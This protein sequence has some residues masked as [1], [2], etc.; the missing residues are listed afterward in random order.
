VSGS[1]SGETSEKV[2]DQPSFR[3]YVGNY[4]FTMRIKRFVA[5]ATALLTLALLYIYAAGRSERIAKFI[6]YKNDLKDA[7]LELHLGGSFANHYNH[8][9]VH[10]F[11]NYY[12]IDG[13]NYQCEFVGENEDFKNWGRLA[14][15]TNQVYLWIDKK[16]RVTPLLNHNT[17]L[18]PEL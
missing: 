4:L 8:T 1:S 11:T 2:C 14:I 13:T 12:V 15:T 9:V 10:V 6:N 17:T 18:P 3:L 16:Q 5:I 7:H